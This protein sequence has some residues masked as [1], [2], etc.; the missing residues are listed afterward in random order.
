MLIS[1]QP[2]TGTEGRLERVFFCLCMYVAGVQ[3]I[4]D[5]S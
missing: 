2:R 4:K 5:D 1:V 3:A